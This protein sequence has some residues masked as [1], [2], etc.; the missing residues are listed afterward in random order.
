MLPFQALSR[1]NGAPASDSICLTP[2]G[3]TGPLH[4]I[5]L[6]YRCGEP[7]SLLSDFLVLSS[8]LLV[9][10]SSEAVG[11]KLYG[12]CQTFK[13]EGCS[14]YLDIF[15]K[16]S[17]ATEALMIIMAV[18]VAI[19]GILLRRT[20]SGVAISPW[21][22]AGLC[23]LLPG[24]T[25]KFIRDSHPHNADDTETLT[26]T[27]FTKAV[28]GTTFSLQH[29]DG[30]GGQ[31]KYG[32]IPHDSRKLGLSE[33]KGNRAKT[34][35]L[36]RGSSN[37]QVKSK[38]AKWRQMVEDHGYSGLFL[39]I[40]C[41][42]LILILYYDTTQLDPLVDSFE[43]FM[44]GQT[45]GIRFFFT[46]LAVVITFFW[47]DLFSRKSISSLPRYPFSDLQCRSL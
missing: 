30:A 21:S 10:I 35:P 17:R 33:P 43:R 15:D 3:F 13:F 1:R 11:I 6:L 36:A 45:F 46:G 28:E 38:N 7:L 14:M 8:S 20:H 24:Q 4:S 31:S 29:Y 23:T 47:D 12:K 41:G 44:D 42:L 32:I 40:H 26:S 27:Q 34:H 37:T 19:M 39:A 16:P 22:I 9:S 2:G 5:K 18:I 25:T